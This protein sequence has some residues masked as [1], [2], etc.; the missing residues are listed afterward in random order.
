MRCILWIAVSDQ[1]QIYRFHEDS[2]TLNIMNRAFTN[3]SAV[4]PTGDGSD[5]FSANPIRYNNGRPELKIPLTDDSG[6]YGDILDYTNKLDYTTG[7][8]VGVGWLY[9]GSPAA[10]RDGTNLLIVL[11][12]SE[13]L[14]FADPALEENAFIMAHQQGV[15]WV[16]REWN[17]LNRFSLG[18]LPG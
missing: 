17:D 7:Q 2:T 10:I 1:N 3:D 11:S 4:P 9:S 5:M 18:R 15:P 12:T 13:V 14:T 8:H 6:V 16:H